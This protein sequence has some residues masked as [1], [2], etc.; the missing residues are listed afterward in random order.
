MFS[1]FF[2]SDNRTVCEI[3]WQNIFQPDRSRMT[4]WPMPITC[5]QSLQ[6]HSQNM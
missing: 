1:N 3:M 2:F 6:T 5:W 4:K